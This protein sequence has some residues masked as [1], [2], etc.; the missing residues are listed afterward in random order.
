M[1]AEWMTGSNAA[2]SGVEQGGLPGHAQRRVSSP[3]RET[4]HI[5][6]R[7]VW[8]II[9]RRSWLVLSVVAVIMSL[10]ALAMAFSERRYQTR[11]TVVLR[12]LDAPRISRTDVQIGTLELSRAIIETQLDVLRSRALVEEVAKALDLFDNPDLAAAPRAFFDKIREALDQF[13]NSNLVPAPDAA[14]PETDDQRYQRVIDMLLAS[15]SVSRSGESLAID[16]IASASDPQLAAD[17]ANTVARTYIRNSI[18][19]RRANIQH[20]V[21]FLMKRVDSLAE[22]LTTEEV[23]MVSFIRDNKLDDKLEPGRLR[24]QV[25]HLSRILDD[26]VANPP[27]SSEAQRVTEQLQRAKV[28]LEAR[29]RAEIT[30]IRMQRGMEFVRSQYEN[31]VETLNELQTRLKLIDGGVRQVSVA[32]VPVNPA[33]PNPPVAMAVSGAAG[34]A[35]AFVL[36]LLAEGLDRRLWNDEQVTRETG[37]ANVGFVPRIDLPRGASADRVIQYLNDNPRSAFAK[38]VRSIVTL[39]LSHDGNG[40]IVMVTSGLPGQGKTRV[41]RALAGSAAL[42]RLRVLIIELDCGD[43]VVMGKAGSG[44]PVFTLSELIGWTRPPTPRMANGRPVDGLDVVR[45][46]T[47]APSNL[48]NPT[49]VFSELRAKLRSCY[50]LVLIDAPPVL[51]D[52]EAGRFGPLVDEILH[53]VRWGKTTEDVL[54]DALERLD[55]LNLPISAT[56]MDDVDFRRHRKLGYGGYARYL[57]RGGAAHV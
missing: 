29:T 11:S 20:T 55:S 40:R 12:Q 39:W 38:C 44:T 54:R 34:L 17:I 33:W 50:D 10:T 5:G 24:S 21:D 37:V 31:V 57:G 26:A 43:P 7:D 18:Q 13:V 3:I 30:Q 16:I 42:D 49:Q 2:V 28:E 14:S 19:E 4:E 46:N 8:S 47:R 53:I 52:D 1:A 6:A 48:K 9:R 35:L 22:R 25:D 23:A 15:Y 56:L 41:T 51:I 45:L 27:N 36:A 32:Q